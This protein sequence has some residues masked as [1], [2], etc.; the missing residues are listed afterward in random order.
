MADSL[1]AEET[2]RVPTN[3]TLSK[4]ASDGG[5]LDPKTSKLRRRLS[6]AM[7][8]LVWNVPGQSRLTRRSMCYVP[9]TLGCCEPCRGWTI[10]AGLSGL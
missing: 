1:E 4:E 3:L 2:E 8:Q 9:S 7:S 6:A 10:R 5:T